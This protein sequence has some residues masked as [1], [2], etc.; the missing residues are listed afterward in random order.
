MDSPSKPKPQEVSKVPSDWP[1]TLLLLALYFGLHLLYFHRLGRFII[2][3]GKEVMAPAL[4]LDGSVLYRDVFWLYGPF[5]PYF[6]ALMYGLFGVHL[7]VLIWV[8]KLLGAGVVIGVYRCLRHLV[9]AS[10][11]FAGALCVLA[12]TTTSVYFAWP[13]SFSNLW[14]TCLALFAID[15]L[16]RWLATGNKRHLVISL[17][18]ASIIACAKFVIALPILA[19]VW[20]VIFLEHKN[21]SP[22]TSAAKRP[23]IPTALGYS[24]A[25]TAVFALITWF[26]STFT[27]PES[28]QLQ[29][30]AGFHARHLFAAELYDRLI[31]TAFL[32]NGLTFESIAAAAGI[33]LCPGSVLFGLLTWLHFWRHDPAHRPKLLLHV[34]TYVFAAGNLLQMNSSVHAPYV[35]PASA[36]LLFS[37]LELWRSRGSYSLWKHRAALG[38]TGCVVAFCVLLGLGR[39]V[40]LRTAP[41]AV[42]SANFEFQWPNTNGKILQNLA[43]DIRQQTHPEDKLIIFTTYDYLYLLCERKPALGYFYTWYEPFHDAAAAQK[44]QQSLQSAEVTLCV[45]HLREPFSL[46]FAPHYRSHPVYQTLRQNFEPQIDRQRWGE[47]IVWKKKLPAKPKP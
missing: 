4:L 30:G 45:T 36:V 13:Y 21:L 14:A 31:E 35:F 15:G 44:V 39:L 19:A 16:T 24:L 28:Y 22:T 29:A 42:T 43:S 33:W 1:F 8:A 20:G 38:L 26:F 18:C 27:S 25:V 46:A 6:N 11:A 40:K 41:F 37:S 17:L 3:S 32:A 12:F 9:P 23:G 47:F 7:D 5:A 2:D 10:T 34:P